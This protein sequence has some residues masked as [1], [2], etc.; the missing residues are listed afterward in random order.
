MNI[1]EKL[2]NVQVKLITPK[3]KKNTFANFN[4]RSAEDILQAVKPLLKEERLSHFINDEIIKIEE[5]FYVKATVTLINNEKSEEIIQVSAYARE[6]E[7]KP[8][9]DESQTTGSA[10]SY[11]RKYALAGLYALDDAKQDNNIELDSQDNTGKKEA[12]KNNNTKLS[13][14]QHNMLQ[15]LYRQDKEIFENVSEA[16]N[17]DVTKVGELSKSKAS[18]L[19][20]NIKDVK[21][22]IKK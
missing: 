11:A 9:M 15:N 13:E 16:L 5:R 2:T 19:I 21:E 1:Y 22:Q 6:P 18:E 10:S 3:D 4:Y 12:N 14:K 20:K 7:I 17:I 8:K